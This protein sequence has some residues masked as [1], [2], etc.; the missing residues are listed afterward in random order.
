MVPVVPDE[1]SPAR[2]LPPALASAL[3]ALGPWVERRLAVYD[4]DEAAAVAAALSAAWE[5]AAPRERG[6]LLAARPA[7]LA[8][9]FTLE[10]DSAVVLLVIAPEAVVQVFDEHAG[11]LDSHSGFGR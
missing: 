9:A 8:P 1:Q 4:L 6:A 3:A 10:E 5:K 7:L 2:A 11:R